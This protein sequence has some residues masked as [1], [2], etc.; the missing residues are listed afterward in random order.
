MATE[1]V[2]ALSDEQ[3]THRMF[4]AERELVTARF[5]HGS[6]ALENTAG[7]SVLRKQVAR[8]KTEARRREND[9]GL[10]KGA[11]IRSHRRTWQATD[12]APEAD[13]PEGGGFL[14]GIVDKLT[15]ND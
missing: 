4:D 15:G 1:S 5:A 14:K 12:V 9:Q 10:A 3:L 8:I 2:T 7:L 11:L 13:A 6:G